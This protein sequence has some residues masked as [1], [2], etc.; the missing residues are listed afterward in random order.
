MFSVTPDTKEACKNVELN[1]F[2]TS[3][4]AC[5]FFLFLFFGVFLVFCFTFFHKT[6]VIYLK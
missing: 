4:G 2:L 5:S 3:F 6:Y 1:C